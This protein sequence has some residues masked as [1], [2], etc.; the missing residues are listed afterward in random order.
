MGGGKRDMTKRSK[1]IRGIVFFTQVPTTR[2]SP[3]E[4]KKKKRKIKILHTTNS[5]FG[6]SLACLQSET[7]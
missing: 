2:A 6:N 7:G 1:I 4:K 3:S 5:A